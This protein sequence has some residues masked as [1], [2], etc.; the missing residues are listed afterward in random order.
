VTSATARSH[1]HK[2]VLMLAS[3]GVIALFG[4]SWLTPVFVLTVLTVN[5]F[6][7]ARAVDSTAAKRLLLVLNWVTLPFGFF[8]LQHVGW[9]GVLSG[10]EAFASPNAAL[11]IGMPFYV[12]SIL[13]INHEIQTNK[14]P[15][16]TWFDYVLYAVYFP[17]FL[18]GPVEQP[19]FLQKLSEYR[20]QFD[21][22]R[23]EAG[24]SWIVLGMFCKFIVAHYM[25][26]NVFWLEVSDLKKMLLT[27]L[28]FEMQVY[29]DLSGYSFMAFGASKVLGLDVTLNF[30]HPFFSGNVRAFWQRWH[31]SLGR[32]FFQYVHMPLKSLDAGSRFLKLGLPLL[33]FLLSA[34]WHGQTL[35]FLVWGTWHGLAY[36]AYVNFLS[37]RKWPWYLAVPSLF[38]VILMGRLLFMESTFPILVLK[39]K[40]MVDGGAWDEM[41]LGFFQVSIDIRD[42]ATFNLIVAFVLCAGYLWLE[43][44][45]QTKA[46]PPY[47]IFHTAWAQWLMIVFGLALFEGR[48]SG[49][50]YARQ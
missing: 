21:A 34:M 20:F 37:K 45:N 26:A 16:P 9:I 36:L 30:N 29:F 8:A 12:L 48:P 11:L 15:R 41:F 4:Q 1:V 39:I 2:A 46:L 42:P 49:F 23:I 32:W 43:A 6:S 27:V 3:L 25:D 50:I 38:G 33:V 40:R 13:A 24:L 18:S 5:F 14:V 44:R 10:G 19:A 22:K 47:L 35:N 7:L 28:A 31:I 17:K